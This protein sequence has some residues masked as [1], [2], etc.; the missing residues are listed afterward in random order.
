MQLSESDL[1][2][3]ENYA[4]GLTKQ[5]V[6][7]ILGISQDS[8]DIESRGMFERAYTKGRALAKARAVESLF[9]AMSGKNGHNAAVEYLTRTADE[10]IK[11]GNCGG[12]KIKVVFEE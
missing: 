4:A 12:G 1:Q 5:E 3:I 9:R 11:T 2:Q 10:W 6:M 8:L 7:D